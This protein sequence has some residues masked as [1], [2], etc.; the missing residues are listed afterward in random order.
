MKYIVKKSQI[1][2]ESKI[3]SSVKMNGK[4]IA[5]NVAGPVAK[6]PLISCGFKLRRRHCGVETGPTDE[7]VTET[8]GQGRS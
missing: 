7:V 3:A 6:L 8:T 1:S 2:K 4:R 5:R